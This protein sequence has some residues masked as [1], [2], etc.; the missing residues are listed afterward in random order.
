LKIRRKKNKMEAENRLFESR[1]RVKLKMY[2]CIIKARRGQEQMKREK[3]ER[4]RKTG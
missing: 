4:E 1:N 3:S 2:N